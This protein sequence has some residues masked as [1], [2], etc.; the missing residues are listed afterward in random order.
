MQ[1]GVNTEK[2]GEDAGFRSIGHLLQRICPV[3]VVVCLLNFALFLAGASYF[4]GD[5]INGT[6]V[7]QRYYLWGYHHGTKDYIE[8][9]KGVR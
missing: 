4:G 7:G 1:N 8:V 6:I 9:T 3:V 5:A 2:A